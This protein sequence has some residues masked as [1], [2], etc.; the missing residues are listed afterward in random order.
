MTEPT[1]RPTPTS[2][3][4]SGATPPPVRRRSMPPARWTSAA[5]FNGAPEIEIEHEGA[6]YRL[7]ITSLGKLI[8]T[9]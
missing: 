4:A 5:I 2:P 6:I 1:P 9:K 7:R 8:L 3:P